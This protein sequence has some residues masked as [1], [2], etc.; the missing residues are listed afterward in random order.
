ML[1]PPNPGASGQS[2]RAA[3]LWSLSR[4]AQVLQEIADYALRNFDSADR[5]LA[6]QLHCDATYLRFWA[7]ATLARHALGRSA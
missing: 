2:R 1:I 4:N 5:V 6:E 3:Q 7:L